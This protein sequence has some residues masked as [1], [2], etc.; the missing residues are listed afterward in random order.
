MQCW[1]SNSVFQL[2][3][4]SSFP[5]TYFLFTMKTI[6]RIL[7]EPSLTVLCWLCRVCLVQAGVIPFYFL[8]MIWRSQS[9]QN[10]G[11]ALPEEARFSC[12]LLASSSF[13]WRIFSLNIFDRQPGLF[14]SESEPRNTP[15]WS[16]GV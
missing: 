15:Q 6:L 2:D 12:H 9:F 10:L 16:V 13:C 5:V 4:Y 8:P 7:L 14:L 1:D 3:A 11:L